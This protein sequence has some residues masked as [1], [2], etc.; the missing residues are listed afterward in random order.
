MSLPDRVARSAAEQTDYRT[1]G[2]G[3]YGPDQSA[4]REAGIIPERLGGGSTSR[5]AHRSKPWT[6]R[7]VDLQRASPA[8]E[9]ILGKR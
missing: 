6:G 7:H 3:R 5:A 1:R 2:R 9:S 4:R 8:Y